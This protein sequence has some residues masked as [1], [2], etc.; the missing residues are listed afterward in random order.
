MTVV[1][2]P[3][4]TL[5]LALGGVVVGACGGAGRHSNV[6]SSAELTSA[7][8]PDARTVDNAGW[9]DA[10]GRTRQV[11]GSAATPMGRGNEVAP[12]APERAAGPS[13]SEPPQATA[14]PAPPASDA[15]ELVERAARAL[16]DREAYCQRIGMGKSF[17]SNDACLVEKRQRVHTVLDRAACTELPGERVAACLSAIRQSACGPSETAL[18]PPEECAKARLCG[19]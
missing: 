11:S 2:P 3:P 6:A 15:T 18:G 7:G 8:S 10:A 4:R 12:R 5:L 17:E 16:C 13:T 9:V 1:H 19:P 14:A